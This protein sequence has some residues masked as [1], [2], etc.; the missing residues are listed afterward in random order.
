MATPSAGVRASRRT[1]AR[2]AATQ[3]A[4][5]P[6]EAEAVVV[7]PEDVDEA[8]GPE[9]VDPMDSVAGG[10]RN[11]ANSAQVSQPTSQASAPVRA[12]SVQGGA[13]ALPMP[14][15]SRQLNPTDFVMPKLRISQ[16]MSKVNTTHA[17]SRGAQGV[18]Q[19]E[20]YNSQNGEKYGEIV[21]FIPVDCRKSRSMF[22]S[23]EGLVCRSFDLVQG[24]GNPGILCEGTP[25]EMRT[26]PAAQRG[27]MLRHWNNE[28]KTP[29]ACG[30]T[31]N[32]AGLI[33]SDPEN[34]DEAKITQVMLQL[35]SKATQAAKAINTFVYNNGGGVWHNVILELKAVSETNIKG[36]FYVP[37]VDLF[38]TTDAP[39]FS[40]LRRR[41][42]S[43]ARAMG[44]RDIRQDLEGD[45]IS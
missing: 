18:Q 6:P 14:D 4:N 43:V 29:P 26:V 15:L 16:A 39:E 34:P 33:V 27:C 21:Y 20:W 41:A 10:L 13:I 12:A 44:N 7:D 45:D 35:R 1:A 8:F 23:G 24:E 9:D 3:A 2:A 37:E 19:G 25:E 38:D 11:A 40:R 31:F 22:I 42:A 17:T 32:Y 30:V 28:T 5:L 36:T